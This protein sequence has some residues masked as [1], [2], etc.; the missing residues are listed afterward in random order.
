MRKSEEGEKHDGVSLSACVP[1]TNEGVIFALTSDDEH[2]FSCGVGCGAAS[3]AVG[4]YR[5]V[6][7]DIGH[8]VFHL[9][10]LVTFC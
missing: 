3:C 7:V 5:V 4:L 1:G 8:Q 10:N 9:V 2:R 6:L